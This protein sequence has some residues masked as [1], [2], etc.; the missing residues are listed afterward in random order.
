MIWRLKDQFLLGFGEGWSLFWSP[1]AAPLA[2]AKA[3]WVAHVPQ[4]RREP[5]ES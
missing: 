1:F 2:R 5:R 3:T 4:D